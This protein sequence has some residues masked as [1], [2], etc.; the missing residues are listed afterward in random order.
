MDLSTGIAVY[1]LMQQLANDKIRFLYHGGE[2]LLNFSFIRDFTE[3]VQRRA[4]NDG[5]QVDFCLQSNGSLVSDVTA[6]YLATNRIGI[7]I[8]LDGANESTN[9]MRI[10]QTGLP[11]F[12]DSLRGLRILLDHGLDPGVI[13]VLT[14]ANYSHITE[15]IDFL[16]EEGVR[17]F[18]LNPLILG[19][20]GSE[21]RQGLSPR[22]YLEV[23]K[24]VI[25]LIAHLDSNRGLRITE[26]NIEY[27]MMN[28]L[29]E[30]RR[31]M[32]LRSPCGAATNLL[33]FAHNGDIFPC[34]DFSG[35][36]S[37]KIANVFDQDA[38]DAVAAS[39]ITTRFAGET[40]DKFDPC[41]CCIWRWVCNAGGCASR[42]FYANNSTAS[43]DPM[44][45]YYRRMLPYLLFHIGTGKLDPIR[46]V[47]PRSARF[48]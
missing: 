32:C 1:R 33:G 37:L 26:R 45:D 28:I 23:N 16:V 18:T 24:Q 4:D 39:A 30:E 22:Q 20:R 47:S 36:A 10:A 6:D 43:P 48:L 31:Y 25:E 7:G 19:G 8:S 5:Y 2:P 40:V 41:R 17:N 9:R 29:S 35:I 13:I 46:F 21:S 12:Q 27:L 42:R 34:D 15:I 11:T 14:Q 3:Y 44:C 38:A